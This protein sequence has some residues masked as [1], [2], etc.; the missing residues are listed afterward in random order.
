[1]VTSPSSGRFVPTL[2]LLCFWPGAPFLPFSPLFC[3]LLSFD[4][5][6]GRVLFLRFALFYFGKMFFHSMFHQCLGEFFFQVVLCVDPIG[7]GISFGNVFLF[8]AGCVLCWWVGLAH[9]C[10]CVG[11]ASALVPLWCL[12]LHGSGCVGGAPLGLAAPPFSPLGLPSWLV[13]PGTG[14]A[15][16]QGAQDA[17]VPQ[18]CLV[19]H[20]RVSLGCAVPCVW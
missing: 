15:S 14:D 3:L 11:G 4:R 8:Q 16:A 10:S 13:W 6:G 18:W 7:L 5:F 9:G 1:M 19:H 17:L 20:G 2:L 12:V